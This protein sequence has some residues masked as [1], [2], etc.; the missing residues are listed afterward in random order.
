LHNLAFTWTCPAACRPNAPVTFANRWYCCRR[1]GAVCTTLGPSGSRRTTRRLDAFDRLPASVSRSRASAAFESGRTTAQA[2]PSCRR[3]VE[4]STFTSAWAEDR[5]AWRTCGSARSFRMKL[6]DKCP[7]TGAG[8]GIGRTIAAR[9]L[10]G[11]FAVLMADLSRN[12]A[13]ESAASL[14]NAEIAPVT[15]VDVTDPN[16]VRRMFQTT[17]WAHRHTR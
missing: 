6:Q 13:A 2:H 17:V 1:S 9:L 12:A 4:R 11:R 7:S 15:C 10:S 16:Q 3:P 8:R 5:S 14:R